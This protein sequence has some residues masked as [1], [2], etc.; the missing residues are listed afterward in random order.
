V[1]NETCVALFCLSNLAWFLWSGKA[2]QGRPRFVLLSSSSC[3]PLVLVLVSC[4]RRLFSCAPVSTNT[5]R[6]L[7]ALRA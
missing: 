2:G 5:T 7:K 3:P 6:Q 1:P 4:P